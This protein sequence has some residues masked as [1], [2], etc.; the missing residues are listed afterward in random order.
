MMKAKPRLKTRTKDQ[1]TKPDAGTAPKL[2]QL[3]GKMKR[4]RL[5]KMLL[6]SE[7]VQ[8]TGSALIGWALGAVW[9]SN[10][11]NGTSTDWEA[12]L[13]GEFPVIVA[14]WHGQHL[15]VPYAA[16]KSRKFTSL[17]SR[18]TDA[19][20][21]ARVLARAGIDV[22]RGSG[23]R[24]TQLVPEKGGVSA[25]L[26]MRTALKHGV[27]VVM[28]ADISKGAPRQAGEGIVTLA[29][30]SGRPIVPVALATSRRHVLEKTWDK[31]TINMPFGNRS[32]RLAPPIFVA[33]TAGKEEMAEARAKVTAELNRVTE[34]AMRA[35]EESK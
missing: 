29:R 11:D 10:G 6:Q 15:L 17:V 34:E 3:S 2:K 21:N 16:P 7:L 12:L 23:G 30:I 5:G 1:M 24:G 9:R 22:I 35:V 26:S 31:T 19:E 4:R 8:R 13:A 20:I 14:L 32:V 18:S 25:L 28:I 33:A 27:N